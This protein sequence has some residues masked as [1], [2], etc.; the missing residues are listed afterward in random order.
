MTLAGCLVVQILPAGLAVFADLR[1]WAHHVRF[2]HVLELLALA[3]ALVALAGRLPGRLAWQSAGLFGLIFLMY[4]TA[5][6]RTVAPVVAALHPVLA[7]L[8]SLA[9]AHV[10]RQAWVLVAPPEAGPRALGAG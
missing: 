7:M 1:Y 6:M 5:N 10:T 8:L 3:M 4:F 2:V 9:A